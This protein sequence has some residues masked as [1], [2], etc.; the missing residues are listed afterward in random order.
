[1]AGGESGVGKDI[2]RA[3]C[4]LISRDYHWSLQLCKI[5]SRVAMIGQMIIPT[6]QPPLPPLAYPYQILYLEIVGKGKERMET[7]GRNM[8]FLKKLA[9]HH[10]ALAFG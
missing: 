8:A 5:Q 1:M 6:S 10:A 3:D 9:T 2:C 4:G 7:D